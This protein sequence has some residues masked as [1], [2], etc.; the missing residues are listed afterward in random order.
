MAASGGQERVVRYVYEFTFSD[1]VHREFAVELLHADLSLR[2]A[3]HG[4]LP[5][6]TRLEYHQ[7]PSC[8]LDPFRC[9]HC[10]VAASVVD[11][12]E[13]F[14]DRKS[15][16][17]VDVRVRAASRDYLRRVPLQQA[18]S[19]LLGIF[20]VSV[21]CPVLDRMRPMLDT[22]L[23]FM[24]SEESSF[25]MVSS[26]L[27]AQFFIARSG[28]RADWK[29]KRFVAHLRR[30]RETNAAFCARLRTLGIRDASLNAVDTL[31]AL[32]ELTALA[33]ETEDLDRWQRL[34]LEHYREEA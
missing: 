32:G 24:S 25:R 20:M 33:L 10:P 27:M 22:H 31:N 12:V 34:F 17:E 26:Y 1:G 2:R 11:V 30:V 16:E 7:C 15:F 9:P 28:G 23:P 4:E 8:P 18:I 14:R 3:A 5:A 6:W 13:A 29:L 21:G 19:S